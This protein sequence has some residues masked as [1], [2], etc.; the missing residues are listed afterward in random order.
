V[1][2]GEGEK[3]KGERRKTKD[4]YRDAEVDSVGQGF[5]P[6]RSRARDSGPGIRARP[7]GTECEMRLTAL[8]FGQRTKIEERKS[9]INSVH[10]ER[11]GGIRLPFPRDG[12]EGT[13]KS[14]RPQRR[15][16][17]GILTL[18]LSSPT[19]FADGH[20]IADTSTR[21][22]DA[23]MVQGQVEFLS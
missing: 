13:A 14:Q 3:S 8:G 23:R 20:A 5:I 22:R 21:R 6:W 16:E 9:K 2:G 4:L 12:W 1:R 10:V 7:P 17:V 15:R 18:D 11:F 19:G